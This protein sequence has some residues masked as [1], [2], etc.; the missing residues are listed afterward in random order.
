MCIVYNN[1]RIILIIDKKSTS[2][3]EPLRIEEDKSLLVR[4]ESTT[5]FSLPLSSTGRHRISK[6]WSKLIP[7]KFVKEQ[8]KLIRAMKDLHPKEEISF[9]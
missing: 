3:R 6:Y 7:L 8:W 4:C 1:T 5:E 9:P 2:I